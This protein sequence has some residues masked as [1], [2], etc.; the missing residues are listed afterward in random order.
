VIGWI[1]CTVIIG[2]TSAQLHGVRVP[3]AVGVAVEREPVMRTL[4]R[5]DRV[6]RA[7]R[8]LACK[9]NVPPGT[10]YT[11]WVGLV[12]GRFMAMVECAHCR[13]EHFGM[14]LGRYTVLP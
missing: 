14:P 6:T 3:I 13:G 7:P 9:H 12:D 10:R 11:E 4:R 1:W 2:A 8:R 5:S